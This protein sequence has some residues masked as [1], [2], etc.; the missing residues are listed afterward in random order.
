MQVHRVTI[1]LHE[2]MSFATRQA[3]GLVTTAPL[4]HPYALGFALGWAGR[5]GGHPNPYMTGVDTQG[6]SDT[7]GADHAGMLQGMP[8]R[9]SAALA[10]RQR[11][12]IR[13]LQRG[14][15]GYR[16]SPLKVQGKTPEDHLTLAW[17][18]DLSH[19][20][21]DKNIHVYA[22][23]QE[24]D[25]GTSLVAYAWGDVPELPRF[26]RVGR[27]MSKAHLKQEEL[28]TRQREGAWES[29]L[30][31]LPEDSPAST[32]HFDVFQMAP[33]PLIMRPSGQ[34]T[35]LEAKNTIDRESVVIPIHNS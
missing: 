8:F 4:I 6:Q 29:E 17:T 7:G 23:S 12:V 30:G 27:W 32:E 20:L 21:K 24:L 16:T 28:Q 2:P 31:L 9:I 10:V 34:G 18:P 3:R 25:T 11:N 22:Q 33:T 5:N 15:E 35:W 13:T 19:S 26:I 1:S 14:Q